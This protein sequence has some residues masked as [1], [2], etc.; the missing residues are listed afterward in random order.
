[1]TPRSKL[2]LVLP[3]IAALV[4]LLVYFGLFSSPVVIAIIFVAYVVVSL[5]NKRKFNRQRAQK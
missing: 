3:V 5:L 1:M 2:L 4:I